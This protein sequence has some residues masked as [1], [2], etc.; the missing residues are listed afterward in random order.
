MMGGGCSGEFPL[1]GSIRLYTVILLLFML[2]YSRTGQGYHSAKLL[3][4]VNLVVY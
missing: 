1:V 2:P 4:W 3:S